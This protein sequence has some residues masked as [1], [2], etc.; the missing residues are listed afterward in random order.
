MSLATIEMSEVFRPDPGLPRADSQVL[1]QLSALAA[2]DAVD[3]AAI[4]ST[5]RTYARALRTAGAPPEKMVVAVKAAASGVG[6]YKDE[7]PRQISVEQI[8]R[9]SIAEYYRAG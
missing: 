7:G 4:E 9:W 6:L 3:E 8:V 5:V 1:R 2:G